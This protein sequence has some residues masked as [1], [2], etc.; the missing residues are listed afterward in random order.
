MKLRFNGLLEKQTNGGGGCNCK[1]AVSGFKFVKSRMFILPSGA[2]KTFY[3]GEVEEV[4][5]TD[6]RFLLS[7]KT[8]DANGT[9]E[10]FTVVEG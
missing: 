9:H 5:D 1:K 3:T 6:A 10:A 8:T 7:F 2:M 4:A